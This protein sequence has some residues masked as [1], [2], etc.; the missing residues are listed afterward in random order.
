MA[1]PQEFTITIDK[2]GQIILDMNGVREKSFKRI[3][4]LLEETVGPVRVVEVTPG[5][6]PQRRLHPQEQE[7]EASEVKMARGE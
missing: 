6:P 4:E 2:D 1:K 5:D 7:E 3:L